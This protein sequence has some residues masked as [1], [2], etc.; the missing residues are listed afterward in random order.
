MNVYHIIYGISYWSKKFNALL[1]PS[2]VPVQI[3][4]PIKLA[5]A[6]RKVHVRKCHAI[7]NRVEYNV[8]FAT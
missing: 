2:S 7:P 8:V 3:C 5:I 6:R 4:G 1:K